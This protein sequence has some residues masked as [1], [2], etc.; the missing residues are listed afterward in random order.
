MPKV[1]PVPYDIKR[2]PKA[3]DDDPMATAMAYA[4]ILLGDKKISIEK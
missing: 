3:K 2:I 4:R 1:Q